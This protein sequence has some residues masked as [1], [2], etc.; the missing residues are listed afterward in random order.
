MGL[1]LFQIEEPEL[2]RRSSGVGFAIFLLVYADLI[3]SR[4]KLSNASLEVISR[5]P[6]YS[7]IVTLLGLSIGFSHF[8]NAVVGNSVSPSGIYFYCGLATVAMACIVFVRAVFGPQPSD[9]LPAV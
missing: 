3:R 5:H 2:W 7:R 8:T 4:K 9:E 1:A 6:W